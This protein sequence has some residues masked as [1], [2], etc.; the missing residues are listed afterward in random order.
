[1]RDFMDKIDGLKDIILRL[2]LQTCNLVQYIDKKLSDELVEAIITKFNSYSDDTEKYFPLVIDADELQKVA[3]NI[4]ENVI[5]YAETNKIFISSDYY[6]LQE[7]RKQSIITSDIDELRNLKKQIFNLE[8]SSNNNQIIEMKN[9]VLIEYLSNLLPYKLFDRYT[10]LKS[11]ILEKDLDNIKR[12]LALISGTGVNPLALFEMET[13]FCDYESFYN[14][15]RERRNSYRVVVPTIIVNGEKI[16]DYKLQENINYHM[17]N[18]RSGVFT[19]NFLTEDTIY[20]RNFQNWYLEETHDII[21]TN[22]KSKQYYKDI[23]N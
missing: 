1:M 22:V 10:V 14:F 17:W 15:L 23:N 2:N 4:D 8:K 3:I 7:L 9:I 19:M 20:H 12:K 6:Q 11:L 21:T 13:I 18:Q 5:S 16:L